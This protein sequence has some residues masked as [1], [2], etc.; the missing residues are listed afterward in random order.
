MRFY[1]DRSDTEITRHN[2]T[3]WQQANCPVFITYRLFDSLPSQLVQQW[4][5]EKETWMKDHP[6]GWTEEE[7]LEYHTRFT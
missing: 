2:L 4:R 5:S 1:N 6:G 3:H 7:D